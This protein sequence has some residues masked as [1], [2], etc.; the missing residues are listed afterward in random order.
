MNED[1]KYRPVVS[2][3]TYE[4]REREPDSRYLKLEE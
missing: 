2:S 4:P 1:N 3:A